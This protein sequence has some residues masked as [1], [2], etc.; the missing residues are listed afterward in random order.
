MFAHDR[1]VI[2]DQHCSIH[3]QSISTKGQDWLSC[4]VKLSIFS[5]ELF[6]VS[7]GFR[8]FWRMEPESTFK[9]VLYESHGFAD[10]Y[11]PPSFP[12]CVKFN[13]GARFRSFGYLFLHSLWVLDHISAVILFFHIFLLCDNANIHSSSLFLIDITM[14]FLG[15]MT[16]F[17]LLYFHS[18]KEAT[19]TSK[20]SI[21]QKSNDNPSGLLDPKDI[22]FTERSKK[23]DKTGKSDDRKVPE[24]TFSSTMATIQ[25]K[26]QRTYVIGIILII[27]C[28]LL[29]TLT[30]TISTDTIWTM[31]IM[32]ALIHLLTAD[33]EF[34]KYQNQR[35]EDIDPSITDSMIY[36]LSFYDPRITAAVSL[37]AAVFMSVMLASRL[38]TNDLALS[39][40]LFAF[41]LF[42]GAPYILRDIKL[43]D[44]TFNVAVS[45]LF[46]VLNCGLIYYQ[47]TICDAL[48]PV[49]EF[50][51][52]L[53]PLEIRPA[54]SAL[55][56]GSV[57]YDYTNDVRL[58][59][60]LNVYQ[61]AMFVVVVLGPV[62]F[63][64][65]QRY[66]VTIS[67]PWTYDTEGEATQYMRDSSNIIKKRD[68]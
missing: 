14:V 32:C 8:I 47:Q 44:N 22:G 61:Y 34:D 26:A 66:K 1:K 16:S 15:L 43:V 4:F 48:S 42:Q 31:T 27:L 18:T 50:V 38:S 67:G 33:Y 58:S 62:G 64:R 2:S 59:C 55:D 20:Q 40:L 3:N 11:T 37:N 49:S 45:V 65:I 35:T 23:S 17:L 29:R 60:L 19:T 28:P 57:Y 36:P 7:V 5:Q 51:R 41:I 39:F 52:N 54:V 68:T 6:R 53:M 25:N 30:E 46:V 24:P 63:Y 12:H 9:R 21:D 56:S 13:D 10:N